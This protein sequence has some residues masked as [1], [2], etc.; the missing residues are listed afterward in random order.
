MSGIKA[1][2]GVIHEAHPELFDMRAMPPQPKVKKPGQI[3]DDLVRKYFKDV[4]KKS[5]LVT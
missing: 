5:V 1:E 3:S 4:S 2:S